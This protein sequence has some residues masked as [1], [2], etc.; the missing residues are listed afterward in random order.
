MDLFAALE[1]VI[2]EHG[3]ASV[4]RDH[5]ALIRDQAKAVEA[6]NA[7]LKKRVAELEVVIQKLGV[8]LRAKAVADE[9]VLHRGAAFKRDGKGGYLQMVFC[10]H[11]HKV[12]SSTFDELPFACVPSCGWVGGF[13]GR[14]LQTVMQDLPS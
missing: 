12:T 11:C 14:N 10:P 7:R 3:S 8:E 2:T 6:E 9:F 1:K 4:L 13:T 5:L